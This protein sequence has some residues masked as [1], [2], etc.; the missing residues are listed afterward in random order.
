MLDSTPTGW[1]TL[2][3]ADL[4]SGSLFKDGD[5]IESKDQSPDGSVRLIQ[6]ADIGDGYFIDKSNRFLTLERAKQLKC[7]FLERDDILVA[8]MPDPIGRCCLFPFDGEEAYVTAVDVCILRA[9]AGINKK[10]L[11]NL[12]NS[13][14]IRS[15]IEQ[16]ATGTTRQ[17]I[18]RKNLGAIRLKVPPLPEQERIAEILTSVDDSIRATEAVIAQAER[19]KRGLMEDLLTGGLGSEAIARGEVPEGWK[20]G[21]FSDLAKIKNGFAFKSKDFTEDLNGT[22][23][24]V[25]MSNFNNGAV[26]LKDCKRIPFQVVEGLERFELAVGDILIAMSGATVGKLGIVPEKEERVFLNQ[27]VGCVVPVDCSS[28]DF[29]WHLMATD[30]FQ[31]LVYQAASG[32]AQPNVSGK[33]IENIST[34]VPPLSEQIRIAGVLGALDEQITSNVKAVAQL[35]TVKRGLMDDLL[36]GRV[37]TV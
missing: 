12:I 31:A 2:S 32:N 10:W 15:E 37:R 35:Q 26:V 17:R 33:Q 8:R 18:S 21:R 29:L 25:R 7:T 23:A 4:L 1:K 22:A 14:R 16:N 34:I 36:T 28:N 27:R 3:L 20:L 13:P 9:K 11:T 6:L 5:W 30:R 19:V 24:V